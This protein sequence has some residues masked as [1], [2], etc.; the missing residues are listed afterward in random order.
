MY[1]KIKDAPFTDE[2]KEEIVALGIVGA[3]WGY[4]EKDLRDPVAYFKTLVAMRTAMPKRKKKGPTKN[5]KMDN[6]DPFSIV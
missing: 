4:P 6:V 2:E 5:E 1:M 3:D